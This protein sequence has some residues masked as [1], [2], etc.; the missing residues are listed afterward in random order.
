[1]PTS[2]S[3]KT[4]F[5]KSADAG[6]G[7]A[8]LLGFTALFAIASVL[9]VTENYFGSLLFISFALMLYV[10]GQDSWRI[11]V[12][13]LRVFISGRHLIAGADYIGEALRDLRR[14]L[15]VTISPAG[16]AELNPA[17]S[18]QSVRLGNNPL[19]AELKK[20]VNDGKG[21]DY[22][23]FVAHHH[24]VECHELYDN[25]SA[26]L[27]FIAVSMPVFGLIGTVLGLMAMFDNLSGQITVDALSPQLAMALKTTLYGA[28]FSAVYKII[29]SRFERR[30]RNLD[31]D[32]ETLCRTLQVV[33]EN[34]MKIEI[35]E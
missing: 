29:G 23:E 12:S 28:L 32:Y 21:F 34:K 25:A 27:D 4:F 3:G 19:T 6:A 1:M 13:S 15:R 35:A 16:K 11:F 24:Y 33:V 10:A 17:H 8:G 9:F 5:A 20:L 31:Y 2:E 26:N 30:I 18:G 14:Q 22:I 7:I